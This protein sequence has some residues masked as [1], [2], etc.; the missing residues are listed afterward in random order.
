[1]SISAPDTA[2]STAATYRAFAG[3]TRGRSP[4]YTEFTL[5][6]AE[7]GEIL[8]FLGTLPIAKRQPNLLFAAARYLLGEPA[9]SATLRAL[10]SDRAAEL[11]RAMLTRRTQRGLT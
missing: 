4:L 8:G 11:T 1:M 10:V 7:D 9:S 2:A 3:E 6:V 5:A